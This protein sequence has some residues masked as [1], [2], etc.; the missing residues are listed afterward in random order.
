MEKIDNKDLELLKIMNKHPHIKEQVRSLFLI[1]EADG[2]GLVR[3]DDAEMKVVENV[4]K[5]GHQV[6]QGW[7]VSQEQI[8]AKQ[9]EAN[10]SVKKHGKKKLAGAQHLA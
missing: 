10:K 5:L 2:E 4:R 7:A 1:A 3:A 8:Q 9:Y 6:L